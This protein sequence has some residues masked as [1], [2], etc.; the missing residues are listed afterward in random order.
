MDPNETLRRLREL[1]DPE[2]SYEGSD[3]T[4]EKLVDAGEL[5]QA[6]DQWLS[7]G[8]FCPE[9]GRGSHVR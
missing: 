8:V 1:L 7:K 2:S 3:G 6:L 5:F 4:L 9:H